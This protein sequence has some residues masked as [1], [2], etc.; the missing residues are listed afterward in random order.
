MAEVKTNLRVLQPSR[1]KLRAGDVFA[2]QMPDDLY[3]FGRV[4][5]TDAVIGPM[6]GIILIYIFRTRSEVK[7]PPRR[8]DLRPDNLLVPPILINRL[9]WSRGYFETID[10]RPLEQEDLLKQNCFLSSVRGQYPSRDAPTTA[11]VAARFANRTPARATGCPS[12]STP[13]TASTC[14]DDTEEKDLAL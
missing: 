7:A 9:P 13:R 5:G 3:L 11:R 1:K 4:I 10:H 14:N 12:A 8:E 6:T 2:M